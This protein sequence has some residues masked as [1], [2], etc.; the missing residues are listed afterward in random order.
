MLPIGAR[1]RNPRRSLASS[2]VSAPISSY[3][4]W[5]PLSLQ[6]KLWL[7]ASDTTTIT[8]SSGAVSEWRDKS[9][10]GY[11][12]TQATGG[13][14]PTT[15]TTTQNGLN[16]LSFD[17]IDD[18][19][20]SSAASSEWKF[21]HDGTEYLV[22]VVGQRS[23]AGVFSPFYSTQTAISGV[24]QIGSR[25]T[26]TVANLLST[27]AAGASGAVVVNASPSIGTGTATRV[28]TV[29]LAPNASIAANRA[30]VQIDAAQP[31]T[32]N[33][34]LGTSSTA[35]PYDTLHLGVLAGVTSSTFNGFIAEIVFITGTAVTTANQQ[36][37]HNYLNRKWAVY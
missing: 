14:Q 22:G 12:F 9:G 24:N 26:F 18:Y 8:D 27:L 30:T 6:P 11:A 21:L 17:G 3:Q 15:G 16:V 10:N 36:L 32:P 20:I 37:L 5:S 2:P 13:A 29:R 35:N 7:D 34:S 31:T 4:P 33:G 23:V 25:M 19:M 28:V 1:L